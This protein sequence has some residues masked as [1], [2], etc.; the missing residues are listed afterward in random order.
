MRRTSRVRPRN[1]LRHHNPRRALPHAASPHAMS[2]QPRV[3]F[4][5]LGIMGA[6]MASRLVARGRQ[7]HGVQP[8]RREDGAPARARRRRRVAPPRRS[9]RHVRRRLRHARR[10]ESRVR[11]SPSGGPD[12]R[13]RRDR[14]ARLKR[15]RRAQHVRR[16]LHRGRRALVRQSRRRRRR[17]TPA[18]GF[19]AAPVS[20]GWR[21]CRVR[22]APLPVR[23]LARGVRR[24][25][26]PARPG[27]HGPPA[28][29][30]SAPRPAE[31]ARAKLMLQV[32]MGNVVGSLAEMM[33]MTRASGLDEGSDSRRL[34]RDAAMG[35]HLC[36]AKGRA[37]AARAT[38]RSELPG[39]PPAEGPA[40]RA[41][42]GGRP[43]RA[44]CPSARR[45]TASTSA[46]GRWASEIRRLRRRK[47]AA[48]D[49]EVLSDKE[50]PEVDA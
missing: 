36:A 44:R 19:L 5:G 4:L 8:Q 40:A 41:A 14:V 39:V 17:A 9:R 16:L 43:G 3:G 28:D 11:R 47:R 49:A 30:C 34:R 22:H 2:S 35:N 32:M 12:S 33:A 25:V 21:D 15:D 38:S 18:A 37:H 26:R 48:Y 45:P 42:A 29:G 20:G 24:R 6:Q 27:R 31:A 23:R 46:R 13:G 7:R 1:D 50:S 10:P